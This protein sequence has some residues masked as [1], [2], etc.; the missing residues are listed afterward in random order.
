VFLHFPESKK[1]IPL[2]VLLIFL[3]GIIS[4]KKKTQNENQEN[5]NAQIEQPG[6]TEVSETETES[7]NNSDFDFYSPACD[8]GEWVEELLARLEEERIADELSSMESSLSEYQNEEMPEAE[9]SGEETEPTESTGSTE[10]EESSEPQLSEVEKFFNQEKADTIIHDK[11]N[12]LKFYESE[13]EIFEPQYQNGSLINIHANGN[14][15][16]RYFYNDNY[17]LV[18]KENWNI[19]SVQGAKLEKTEKYEYYPDSNVISKK[20]ITTLES[21]ENLTYSETS[22]ILTSEKYAIAEEKNQ[23]TS[24]RKFSYDGEDRLISDSL[25]EYFYKDKEYKE[26]D[27]SFTKKYDYAYNEGEI[28]PDFKYYENGVLKMLNKYSSEKG[29]YVSEIFFDKTFSVKT[30]YENDVRVKDIFYSGGK[31]T[32]EK[33]YDKMD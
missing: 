27:Y 9:K 15:I 5:Q 16:D 11:N 10:S 1:I 25:T 29:K 2:F 24:K 7:D 17:Q 28:P 14:Y 21:Q 18:K 31:V 30:Y 3:C 22:K 20:T 26:L 4:C 19:P 33:V 8:N 13:N 23:I 32:R 6:Q 12:K